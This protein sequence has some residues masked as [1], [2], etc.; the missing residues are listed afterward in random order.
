MKIIFTKGDRQRV[1]KIKSFYWSL[2]IFGWTLIPYMYMKAKTEQIIMGLLSIPFL[3]CLIL[4]HL[5]G[6]FIIGL[7]AI[8]IINFFTLLLVSC[9]YASDG[10]RIYVKS[11]LKDGWKIT[12]R[13]HAALAALTVLGIC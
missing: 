10:Y 6:N 1:V 8:S 11:L 5:H 13:N 9:H 3:V 2:F 4:Y 7:E 12:D